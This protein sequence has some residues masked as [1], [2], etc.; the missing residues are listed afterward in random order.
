MGKLSNLDLTAEVTNKLG[1]K[2]NPKLGNFCFGKLMN[3]ELIMTE[4]K[5]IKDNGE[6]STWEYAGMTIPS[7]KFSF[8]NH[9][10]IPNE[11]DRYFNH[12]ER[13]IGLNTQLGVRMEQNDIDSL[14]INMWKRIKHIYDAYSKSETFKPMSEKTLQAM[15]R[16][17]KLADEESASVVTT[18]ALNKAFTDFYKE[19]VEDFNRNG[20]PIYKDNNGK[21][22]IMRMRLV[23]EYKTGKW[24][25]FPSF[26]GKGFIEMYIKDAPTALEPL[27]DADV[28]LNTTKTKPSTGNILNGGNDSDL[29]PELRAAMGL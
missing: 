2:P 24:Y 10:M 6:E 1:F 7:I 9:K 20:R 13:V 28:A 22:Y 23:P 17:A 11:P 25:V 14:F 8:E 19:V 4:I 16:L 5:K 27:S 18:V 15:Q 21:P 26:V 12:I 29:D 3:V